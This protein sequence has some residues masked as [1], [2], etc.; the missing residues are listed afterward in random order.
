MADSNKPNCAKALEY[1]DHVLANE[2]RYEA[3]SQNLARCY[4]EREAMLGECHDLLTRIEM[5]MHFNPESALGMEVHSLAR[6]LST[7]GK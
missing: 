5:G 6:R 4:L 7:E 2:S 1:A 3:G